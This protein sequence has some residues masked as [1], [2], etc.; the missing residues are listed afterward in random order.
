MLAGEIR[1]TAGEVLLCGTDPDKSQNSQYDPTGSLGY[2]PQDNPLWPNLTVK[3]HLE[4]YAAVKGL[5][6]KDAETAIKRVSEALELKEHLEKAARKLSAGVSRKVCFAISMLGNPNI[7]LL[8]EPS[9]GLD[10]KGQQRL[11][12]A[13]RSAFRNKDRGAILTTHYM[14]EAEA[15]C[16][17]V[18]IMVS[19]KLRCIG[20]IQQLKSK[21]GKGYLLE[22]KVKNSNQ[23][24]QIHNEIIQI[25]PHAARQDRFSS[26][27]VYKI[28]VENVQ[29]LS[30]AFLDLEEAKRAYNIEEYSFSQPTLTQVFIEL[31]KEQER[32]DF[33]SAS[34]FQWKQLR[35]ESEGLA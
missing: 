29:S 2:C 27:L 20:S 10:P 30:K 33:D 24:D 12:R 8:D 18:A 11:W 25:F 28:P 7:V 4:I 15:V 1:P 31:T 35:T 17:R 14:E 19:G 32:E 5:K 21:F 6:K 26:L 16:D 22:I 23:V 9:T 3:Q 34:T 13:I